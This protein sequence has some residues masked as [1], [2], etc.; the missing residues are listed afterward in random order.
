MWF[1][2]QVIPLLSVIST[3][4]IPHQELLQNFLAVFKL[5]LK[6]IL[7]HLWY[8]PG[9]DARLFIYGCSGTVFSPN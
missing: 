6:F 8:V 9:N 4:N 5:L 1:V 2:L 7:A 3:T